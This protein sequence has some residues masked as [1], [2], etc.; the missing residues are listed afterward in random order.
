[1]HKYGI[2]AWIWSRMFRLFAKLSDK[3]TSK[4]L[5]RG[6]L[7]R[8][9]LINFGMKKPLAPFDRPVDLSKKVK[10]I[11]HDGFNIVYYI[12]KP[13]TKLRKWIYGYDIY[14]DIKKRFEGRANFIV[15]NPK[16]EVRHIYEIA[17][18]LIRPNRH[19]GSPRMIK[20][21]IM[22]NIPA[23]YSLEKPELS[24]FIYVIE[25]YLKHYEQDRK[26]SL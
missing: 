6:E 24:H 16:M 15:C 10:R 21:C 4:H 22:N 3:M 26:N 17:D 9:N 8:R 14:F 23:I 11:N 18:L 1:M 13:I 5:Y 7:V 20:E 12:P 25:K 19:D 2:R